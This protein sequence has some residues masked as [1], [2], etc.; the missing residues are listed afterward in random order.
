MESENPEATRMSFAEHY[1]ELA[2][3]VIRVTGPVLIAFG[4][5]SGF[6]D[7]CDSAFYALIGRLTGVPRAA[8]LIVFDRWMW[9]SAVAFL[10]GFCQLVRHLS[11]FVEPGL[12]TEELYQFRVT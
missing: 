6:S 12:H 11:A 3:R 4:I 9:A 1:H 2:A 8:P 10:I 5:A 7:R